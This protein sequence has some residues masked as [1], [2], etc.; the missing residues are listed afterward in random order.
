MLAKEE[1]IDFINLLA[2][3][4]IRFKEIHWLNTSKAIHE[5]TDNLGWNIERVMD[6]FTEEFL[7]IYDRNALQPNDFNATILLSDEFEITLQSLTDDV[8]AFRS[9]LTDPVYNGLNSNLDNFISEI[10]ITT[11]RGGLN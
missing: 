8:N 4:K 2:G 11:Y 6:S 5:A 3:Y 7:S 1:F 10:N 9:K